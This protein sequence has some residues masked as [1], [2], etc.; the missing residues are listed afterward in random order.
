MKI[1]FPDTHH[2][3]STMIANQKFDKFG[4]ILLLQ[5]LLTLFS[6]PPINQD[7]VLL[8][9]L[10]LKLVINVMSLKRILHQLPIVTGI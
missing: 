4:T 6:G 10:A 9:S 2:N 1:S 7:N 3:T 8:Q 5:Q